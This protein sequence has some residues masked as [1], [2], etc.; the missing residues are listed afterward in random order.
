MSVLVINGP[1]LNTLGQREPDIY[2]RETLADVEAR[3]RQ[4]GDAVGLVL[5]FFQSNHEGAIIDCLQAKAPESQGVIINPGALAHTSIALRDAVAALSV[6][7]VEVHIS[8]VHARERFRRRSYLAGVATGQVVGLGTQGYVLAM[9]Y[10]I[11][12]A[13]QGGGA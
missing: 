2:G 1:N 12:R 10:L 13:N 7:V 4:Y 5:D 9:D 3:M 6:P 8:N 11:H